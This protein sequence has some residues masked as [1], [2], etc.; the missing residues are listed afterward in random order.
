VQKTES[1]SYC[2]PSVVLEPDLRCRDRSTPPRGAAE[3]KKFVEA[4]KRDSGVSAR[5]LEDR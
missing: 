4:R 1:E 5:I 3:E 2:D